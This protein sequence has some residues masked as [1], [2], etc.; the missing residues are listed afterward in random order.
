MIEDYLSLTLKNF[1]H[2]KKRTFLTLIGI[3]I[4]IA[5]LVSLVS[6]GQ[7]LQKSISDQ[8]AQLGTDKIF[9]LPGSGFFETSAKGVAITDKDLKDIR[10]SKGVQE[11]AGNIFKIGRVKVGDTLVYNNVLGTPLDQTRKVTES[12]FKLKVMKGRELKSGDRY[13]AFVGPR[14]AKD[15]D[16]LPKGI[17]VGSRLEVENK[18]FRVV[19][20]FESLGNPDDDSLVMIP[21]DTA[22]D[23]FDQPDSFD[24]VIAQASEGAEPAVVAEAIKKKMRGSRNLEEGEE[25][26]NVSTSED[27]IQSFN[28]VLL[29]VQIIVIGIAFI[30]L[31]VGGINITN[32]M[33][34]SVIERT[35]D[36]GVMKAIGARNGDILA[37]F[38]MEAGILG[39]V[40]GSIGIIFGV[41]LSQLVS[42]AANAAGLGFIKAF[43]PWYLIL[44]ALLFSFTVGAIA[45]IIPAMNAARLKPVD[46]L[47]YE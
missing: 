28:A 8:F 45:G 15:K 13:A 42:L 34:T 10:N 46:A 39:L 2:Q 3:F 31:L 11:V 32:T 9:I 18:T 44:G 40:G 30:S 6:L 35:G 38:M 12:A 20:F 37:L 19:G 14:W 27:L 26:F 36:I 47:R 33:Y 43:F 5:A 17:G 29:I 41:G 23:L 24:Y 16:I 4:G 7:G 25:N 1:S 22:K 21:Y